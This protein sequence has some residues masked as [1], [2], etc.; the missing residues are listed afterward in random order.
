MAEHLEAKLRKAADDF[1]F[2]FLSELALFERLL[3]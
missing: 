3:S 1:T 2:S